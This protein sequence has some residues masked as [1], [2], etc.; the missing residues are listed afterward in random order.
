MLQYF[1]ILFLVV[2]IHNDKLSYVLVSRFKVLLYLPLS[3]FLLG[4]ATQDID[5]LHSVILRDRD[6]KSLI[7]WITIWTKMPQWLRRNM[8]ADDS[9]SQSKLI[10]KQFHFSQIHTG[11]QIYRG[12]NKCIYLYR[13]ISQCPFAGC[14]YFLWE[15]KLLW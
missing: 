15:D 13:H 5:N 2:A 9:A 8:Y 14:T 12:S 6:A 11:S 7:A 10:W 1:I 4:L 3:M